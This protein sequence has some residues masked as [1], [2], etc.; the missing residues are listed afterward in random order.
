MS[1][2]Q[3]VAVAQLCSPVILSPICHMLCAERKYTFKKQHQYTEKGKGTDYTDKYK[4][5]TYAKK[6]SRY[7][8]VN[9]D[10]HDKQ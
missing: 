5:V 10:A 7:K 2:S 6:Q 4:N 3:I 9:G 1:A 8:E